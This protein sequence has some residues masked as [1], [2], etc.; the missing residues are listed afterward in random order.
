MRARRVGRG[1][2]EESEERV[3]QERERFSVY[4]N[5]NQFEALERLQAL[6]GHETV[7]ETIVAALKLYGLE[8]SNGRIERRASKKPKRKRGG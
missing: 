4:L 7:E 5:R 8:L 6:C 3:N 2:E 1:E